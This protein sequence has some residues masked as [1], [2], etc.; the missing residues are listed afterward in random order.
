MRSNASQEKGK[1][2]GVASALIE[3][4]KKAPEGG[5]FCFEF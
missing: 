5:S 1:L 2:E 3:E 4:M